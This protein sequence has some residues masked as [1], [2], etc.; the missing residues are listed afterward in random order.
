MVS[1]HPLTW[2]RDISG[3]PLAFVPILAHC[4]PDPSFWLIAP[5]VSYLCRKHHIG[6]GG[7]ISAP[8]ASYRLSI[9]AV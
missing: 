8:E 1:S 5:E 9:L 4:E 3:L 2:P 7:V 6:A